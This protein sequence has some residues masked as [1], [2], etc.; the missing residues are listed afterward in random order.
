M[1]KWNVI[2]EMDEEETGNPTCW[3]AEI[4]SPKYGKFIWITLDYLDKYNVE[5][6][7]DGAF[8]TLISCKSLASAKRWVT[9]YIK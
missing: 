1:T 6:S 3:A 5:I 7:T 2:H 8:K 9:R 4:N